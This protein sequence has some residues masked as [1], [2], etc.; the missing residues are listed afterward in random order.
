MRILLGE[1]EG[2]IALDLETMLIDLGYEVIGPAGSL[3][4]VMAA[5]G[6]CD[7]ALL[8]VNLRGELVFPAARLLLSRGVPV[9][10]S[11]GYDDGGEFPAEFRD[12]PRLMK[13]YDNGALRAV[14]RRAFCGGD[15]A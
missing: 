11:S 8:D 6:D 3:E 1:D 13:P 2:L 12:V 10:F 5:T 14:C 9:I 7:G 4:E 15:A